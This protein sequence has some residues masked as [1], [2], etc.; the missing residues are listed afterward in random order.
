MSVDR[1]L[2][3]IHARQATRA[4]QAALVVAGGG[5][6]GWLVTAITVADQMPGALE[7]F[8]FLGVFGLG[9]ALTAVLYTLVSAAQT[10]AEAAA[11]R[12]RGLALEAEQ[13]RMSEDASGGP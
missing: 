12:H 10:Y 5:G 2:A 13:A 11:V 7:A 6:F 9:L 8:A 3:Q 4:G 1:E